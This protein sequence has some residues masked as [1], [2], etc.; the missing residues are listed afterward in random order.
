MF[1]WCYN[2]LFRTLTR[3]WDFAGEK[4]QGH[5]ECTYAC[6]YQDEK[7]RLF[8]GGMHNRRNNPK[9]PSVWGPWLL[10]FRPLRVPQEVF[11]AVAFSLFTEFEICFN[12]LKGIISKKMARSSPRLLGDHG[13]RGPL[14]ALEVCIATASVLPLLR[15]L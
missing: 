15:I 6:M 2:E 9:Q 13:Q 11:F 1:K 10:A 5:L 14:G 12:K 8:L 3:G 7:N 4:P